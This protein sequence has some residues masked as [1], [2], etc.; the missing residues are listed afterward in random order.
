MIRR[1]QL[2]LAADALLCTFRLL[3]DQDVDEWSGVHCSKLLPRSR[4]DAQG[5]LTTRSLIGSNCVAF[6]NSSTPRKLISFSSS[7][8]SDGRE[9]VLTLIGLSDMVLKIYFHS[10]PADKLI[11]SCRF[12]VIKSSD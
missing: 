1:L 12:R 7:E 4:Y 2:V 8:W 11:C 6:R 10:T 9:V 3:P 5:T